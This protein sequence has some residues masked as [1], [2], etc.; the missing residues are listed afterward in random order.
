MKNK[1]FLFGILGGISFLNAQVGVNTTSPGATLDVVAKNTSTTSV[2]G[3]IAPRVDRLKASTMVGVQ[4]GTFIYVNDASTGTA[5]GQAVNINTTGYYYFEGSTW[6]KFAGGGGSSGANIYTTDGS[7]TGNRNVDLGGNTLRFSGP[8]NV[9]IGTTA[10][11]ND[12]ILDTSAPNKGFLMP[13]IALTGTNASAPLSSHTA[14]MLV[15]NTASAGVSPNDVTPGIYY[16]DGTK[17]YKTNQTTGTQSGS[18]VNY[19]GFINASTATNS[20]IQL[21]NLQVRYNGT[22]TAGT[23]SFRNIGS[24]PIYAYYFAV[25][26]HTSNSSTTY[27]GPYTLQP[28]V[29]VETYSYG[30]QNSEGTIMQLDTYD[31]SPADGTT[32]KSYNLSTRMFYASEVGAVGD[33]MFMRFFR[34]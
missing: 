12:A 33:Y 13:R 32:V 20:V 14:G 16:N 3:I 2:D 21:G 19:Q 11:N 15:Y 29:W 27:D 25:W 22:N 8:G 28:N 1:T 26:G 30:S 17:W 23:I 9:G 4:N 31:P 24:H 6:Q 10:P 5:T 7:L 18:S 34:N